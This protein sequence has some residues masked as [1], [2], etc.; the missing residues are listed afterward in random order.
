MAA[1]RFVFDLQDTID[2]TCGTADRLTYST[3][4]K[5]QI[6]FREVILPPPNLNFS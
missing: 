1:C 6:D 2:G 3:S 5:V 4:D